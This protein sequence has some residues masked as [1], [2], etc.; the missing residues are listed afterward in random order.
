MSCISKLGLEFMA[1]PQAAVKL[2]LGGQKPSKEV[3]KCTR[4]FP[5][6]VPGKIT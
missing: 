6:N 1:L 4:S 5:G 3:P 2:E